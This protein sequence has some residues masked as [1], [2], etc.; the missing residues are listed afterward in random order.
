VLANALRA[1][2]IEAE[3]G[4]AREEV[5]VISGGALD[6]WRRRR[7]NRSPAT[8]LS[9]D[10]LGAINDLLAWEAGARARIADAKERRR[11]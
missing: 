9:A 7:S 3:L 11:R 6:V 2:W 10:Q 4:A 1:G 5:P 8:E